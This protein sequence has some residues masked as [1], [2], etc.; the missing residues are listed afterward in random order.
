MIDEQ[1]KDFFTILL[2]APCF[3]SLSALKR[4][5]TSHPIASHRIITS[6]SKESGLDKIGFPLSKQASHVGMVSMTMTRTCHD[7]D[8]SK[9]M[10]R[11]KG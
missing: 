3:L 5:I 7:F 2:L 4:C 11:R 8:V 6:Q 1:M 10:T 9:G